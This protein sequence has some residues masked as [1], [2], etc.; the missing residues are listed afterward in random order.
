[1]E[2]TNIALNWITIKQSMMVA[3]VCILFLTQ[4]IFVSGIHQNAEFDARDELTS[5]FLTVEE[6][7]NNTRV[8]EREIASCINITSKKETCSFEHF[9]FASQHIKNSIP[10]FQRILANEKEASTISGVNAFGLLLV[11]LKQYQNDGDAKSFFQDLKNDIPAIERVYLQMQDLQVKR[12]TEIYQKRVRQLMLV[13]FIAAACL[14]IMIVFYSGRRHK[15]GSD[16]SQASSHLI[17]AI[18]SWDEETIRGNVTKTDFH[19]RERKCYSRL[20]SVNEDIRALQ[21]KLDLYAS[22]Y[23]V[24]GYEIR[25]ITNKVKGG[26]DVIAED[27]DEDARVILRQITMAAHTLEGLAENFNQLFSAGKIEQSNIVNLYELVS[28]IC[29]TVSSKIARNGGM[30][31]AYFDKS[32]PPTIY[33]NYISFFWF[34][35]LQFSDEITSEMKAQNAR[36]A[37]LMLRAQSVSGA[38]SLQIQFDLIFTDSF[39]YGLRHYE[40]LRWQKADDTHISDKNLMQHLLQDNEDFSIS[41]YMHG[42]EHKLSIALNV[43]PQ[44]YPKYEQVLEG[45]KILLCGDNITQIDVLASTLEDYGASISYAKAANDVFKEIHS[46][47]RFDAVFIT[48][49]ITG[50]S[51][52]SLCKTLNSRLKKMGGETKLIA[53]VFDP[54]CVK[55]IYAQ[56]DQVFYR[57]CDPQFMMTVLKGILAGEVEEKSNYTKSVMIVEDDQL[58][59]MVLGRILAELDVNFQCYSTGEEAIEAF[60]QQRPILVFMDCIMPGMGGVEA[61]KFMR[62]HEAKAG[63]ETPVTIIG[64]SALTSED[65]RREAIHAG[66]DLMINKPYKRAEIAKVIKKYMAAHRPDVKVGGA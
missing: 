19:E 20:L 4:A 45:R 27:M 30:M 18:E 32:L 43:A 6:I 56:V 34:L 36:N 48:E 1:M 24:I 12:H 55:E 65:K 13:S 25:D 51:L 57:P 22:L 5:I 58:Q 29:V 14:I 47:H 38:A 17:E 66:M 59:Q 50:V 64:A 15:G 31:E 10:A 40:A 33:G 44:S 2:Q 53:A 3:L 11:N 35:L 26:I 54:A 61:T 37:L 49:S 8:L 23:N 28:D 46:K 62:L 39:G 9:E 16:T 7:L 52:P 21:H 63:I 60:S 42:T 41:R